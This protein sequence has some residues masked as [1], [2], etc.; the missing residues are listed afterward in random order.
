MAS[1]GLMVCRFQ[2]MSVNILEMIHS[3]ITIGW[4]F[5]L[6]PKK[7]LKLMNQMRIRHI[8]AH[9]LM[10]LSTLIVDKL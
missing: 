8:K 5:I 1:P 9:R 4:M 10:I 7:V 3:K 6:V 2:K